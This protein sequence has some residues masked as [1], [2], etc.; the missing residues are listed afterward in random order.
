MLYFYFARG[1][2]SYIL[3]R[4]DE[5]DNMMLRI[6]IRTNYNSSFK[7][8]VILNLYFLIL[9]I[10]I[11]FLHYAIVE[12][13]F[14]LAINYLITN[15]I[16]NAMVCYITIIFHDIKNKFKA[17]NLYFSTEICP[18]S[19]NK[20]KFVHV[21]DPSRNLEQELNV[22]LLIYKELNIYANY[23]KDTFGIIL[24]LIVVCYFWLFVTTIYYSIVCMIQKNDWNE[25][26]NIIIVSYCWNLLI[27]IK[28][29]F[30]FSY[31][32]ES[33]FEVSDI[34]FYIPSQA[35]LYKLYK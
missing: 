29:H 10:I 21:F 26:K 3:N 28:I 31:L 15:C 20:I 14:L 18:N 25:M 34:L 23:V 30:L 9:Y 24:I 4:S 22:F 1:R 27:A 6:R 5:L 19:N 8:C 2:I 12:R 33:T 35:T 13:N 16:T 17:L 7:F 32:I 11:V